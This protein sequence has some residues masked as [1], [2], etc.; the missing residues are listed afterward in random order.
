MFVRN[1]HD[2][3]SKFDRIDVMILCELLRL[4]HLHTKRIERA[5]G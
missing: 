3:F 4:F 1:A 2:V 5:G